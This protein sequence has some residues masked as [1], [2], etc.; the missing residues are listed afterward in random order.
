MYDRSEAERL[1]KVESLDTLIVP[2][3]RWAVSHRFAELEGK[4][5]TSGKLSG[6]RLD[7]AQQDIVFRLGKNG[8]SLR[9]ESRMVPSGIPSRFVL[10]RPFLIYMKQRGAVMPYFVMWVENTE[11][12]SQWDSGQAK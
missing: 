8:A 3:L 11:L 2:D 10:D 1:G 5:F 6:Q 7:V 4:I 9:S 12:L